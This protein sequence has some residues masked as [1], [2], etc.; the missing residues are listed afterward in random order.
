MYSMVMRVPHSVSYTGHLLRG[1]L[2][3]SHTQDKDKY[4]RWW[5]CQLTSM[6]SS[7]HYIYRS[8]HHIVH[9]KY[10]FI[11]Q[12]DIN[13]AERYKIKSWIDCLVWSKLVMYHFKLLPLIISDEFNP[14][15]LFLLMI[16]LSAWWQEI[17]STNLPLNSLAVTLAEVFDNFLTTW[18]DNVF[19]DYLINFL[20]SW[21]RIERNHFSRKHYSF[22]WTM[23]YRYYNRWLRVP[24][25]GGYFS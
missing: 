24:V 25:V 12:L 9:L 10:N 3:C 4:V 14:L 17:F 18:Y 23:F 2:T 16:E 7:F 20:I 5:E 15:Q 6:W 21:T 19:W 22:Y 1:E 8:N 11:C 13:K